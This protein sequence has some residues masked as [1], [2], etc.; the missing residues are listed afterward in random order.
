M[1]LGFL[2][3]FLCFLK[4]LLFL[5]L[6]ITFSFADNHLIL[7][8]YANS[9]EECFVFFDIVVQVSKHMG[10]NL[11]L[12]HSFSKSFYF[13]FFFMRFL[14][15]F[16]HLVNLLRIFKSYLKS[17]LRSVDRD[18]FFKLWYKGQCLL[19]AAI[20]RIDLHICFIHSLHDN[21]D[22]ELFA[23]CGVHTFLSNDICNFFLKIVKLIISFKLRHLQLSFV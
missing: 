7:N 8:L 19:F 18:D 5:F 23:I 2:G 14:N 6:P 13:A 3:W 10:L 12:H 11:K 17:H 15:K 9:I 22:W 1:I 21:A 16:L 4:M 20:F